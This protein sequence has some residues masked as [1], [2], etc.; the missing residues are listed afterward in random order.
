MR[1]PSD[2]LQQIGGEE[3][4]L[5]P[6]ADLQV[7]VDLLAFLHYNL[8]KAEEQTC[9][10]DLVSAPENTCVNLVFL[11]RDLAHL[12]VANKGASHL[13]DALSRSYSDDVAGGKEAASLLYPALA[14]QRRFANDL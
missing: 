3:A 11:Q 13:V 2:L 14:A 9:V 8:G 6:C 5:S 4:Q 12:S 10:L 1:P 7:A